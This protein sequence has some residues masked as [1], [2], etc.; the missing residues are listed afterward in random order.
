MKAMVAKDGKFGKPMVELKEVINMSQ[1]QTP[2]Q[3]Q[4]L[5]N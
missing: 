5:I 4:R 1:E 3:N 2:L